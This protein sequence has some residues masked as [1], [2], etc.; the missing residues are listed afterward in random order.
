M[1]D[2]IS[3]VQ[4]H[5]RGKKENLASEVLAML[6]RE[7]PGQRVLRELLAISEKNDSEIDVVT[8]RMV[9]GCIPDIHFVQDGRL[10]GFLE[11]KF[12]A[13]FTEHQWSGKYCVAAPQVIFLLPEERIKK[14]VVLPTGTYVRSLAWQG[15]LNLLQRAAGSDEMSDTVLF[16]AALEH[17]EEFC[18][19]IEQKRFQPFTVQE[20]QQPPSDLGERH[21]LWLVTEVIGEA[22]KAAIISESGRLSAGFDSTFFYGQNVQL[23]TSRVWVGYWPH[24]WKKKPELG[25][26]WAQFSGPIA[27]KMKQT[28]VFVDGR[29]IMENDLA[30]SLFGVSGGTRSTQEEEVATIVDQLK[31]LKQRV[32]DAGL[33]GE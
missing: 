1:Q 9:S 20:I 11:V 33:L 24:A 29:R 10:L 4:S 25:P 32:A 18:D 3:F 30:F 31:S 13:D 6:L 7:D 8:Q 17:L 14:G 19:L 28:K 21:W 26:I 16:N 12:W 5:S 2:L 23:G 27:T 15:L 22:A